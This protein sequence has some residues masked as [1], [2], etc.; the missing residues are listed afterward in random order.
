MIF[1][2]ADWTWNVAY[3][4]STVT[5]AT[6]SS[7]VTIPSGSSYTKSITF[8]YNSTQTDAAHNTYQITITPKAGTGDEKLS[9]TSTATTQNKLYASAGI[10]GTSTDRTKVTF[11]VTVTSANTSVRSRRSTAERGWS[12]ILKTGA[13][14]NKYA[15][16]GDRSR[17]AS[18]PH[19]TPAYDR[20]EV[21]P[22]HRSGCPLSSIPAPPQR[23]RSVPARAA[24][25]T[26]TVTPYNNSTALRT[27]RRP[28]RSIPR[29]ECQHL[30]R[31]QRNDSEQLYK[32]QQQ[33]YADRIGHGSCLGQILRMDHQ[34]GQHGRDAGFQ[35]RLLGDGKISD[36]L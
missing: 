19:S 14:G 9:S 2:A 28:I 18:T 1:A 6:A 4:D 11:T 12:R 16:P 35:Y 32:R 27:M 15:L 29:K 13:T 30:W 34:R 24:R 17:S 5:D 31:H 10:Y 26:L 7:Y 25:V 20:M 33:R 23:S 22:L 8:R 21:E 3:V 36:T